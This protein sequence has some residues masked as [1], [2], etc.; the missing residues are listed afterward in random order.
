MGWPGLERL[1]SAHV[2]QPSPGPGLQ[3]ATPTVPLSSC[4]TGQT[5]EG[6]ERVGIS[7]DII[8]WSWSWSCWSFCYYRSWQYYS[9]SGRSGTGGSC[10]GEPMLCVAASFT[11]SLWTTLLNF[12]DFIVPI[13]KG[14]LLSTDF[15][16]RLKLNPSAFKLTI[17]MIT[18]HNHDENLKDTSLFPYFDTRLG[19]TVFTS[20]QSAEDI[21]FME[22]KYDDHPIRVDQDYNLKLNR[23]MALNVFALS[24]DVLLNFLTKK[25]IFFKSDIHPA[26]NK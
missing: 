18:I 15:I 20:W 9:C 13:T 6:I 7:Q 5:S 21:T 23:K 8:W 14:S 10:C 4:R 17:S 24:V 19:V 1:S 3:P 16:I 22:W 11:S 25:Y 26:L 12:S 2:H